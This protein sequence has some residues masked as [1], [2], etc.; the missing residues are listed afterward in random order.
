[1]LDIKFKEHA[2][3]AFSVFVCLLVG[4]LD[5]FVFST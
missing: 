3:I 5:F 4:L 2:L 1:M